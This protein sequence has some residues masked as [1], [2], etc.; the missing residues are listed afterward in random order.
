MNTTEK[1]TNVPL[2]ILSVLLMIGGSCLLGIAINV[3]YG[4]SSALLTLFLAL[5]SVLF[6]IFGASLFGRSFHF[7][8]FDDDHNGVAFA[9]LLIAV[10]TM[11]IC[12]NT[13]VL[14]PVWKPF[15]F[16]WQ[17]LLFV[18]GILIFRVQILFGVSPSEDEPTHM[19]HIG[20]R[21]LWSIVVAA[22]GIFFLME[23]AETLFPNVI[24]YEKFASNFWPAIF[25]IIG[26]AIVLSF[27]IRPIKCGRK[28][29][30]GFWTD[31]YQ[32][33]ENENNDGKINY[34]FVFSGAEQVILDPVFKGGTIE[35]TFG[36]LELDLRRTSL[37]E[38][39]TY[40]YISTTFG[41]V[42]IKAPDSWDIELVSKTVAGGI[43]DGRKKVSDIDHSRKLVIVGKCVL[44]GISIH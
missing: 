33:S 24:Q 41:G 36:G 28:H 1:K 40:L 30:K 2:V 37:A 3:L 31:H 15:F 14:N 34:R 35:T 5:S 11:M 18:I 43:N 44:G 17:M 27:I 8:H 23:K 7:K 4:H 32:P 10:G 6:F 12:F 19:R 22:I 20:S 25:I 38:G 39:K 16:S 29:P 21:F 13:E 42:D 26:I 9:F